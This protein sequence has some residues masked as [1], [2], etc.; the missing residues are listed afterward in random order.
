MEFS[1]EENLLG[2]TR[3]RLARFFRLKLSSDFKILCTYH[4]IHAL[5]GGMI[6][7]FLP[8]FLL[9]EFNN[10][11]YWVIVFYAAGHLVYGLLAPFGAMWMEKIGLKKS[12]II[13][14][15]F[16]IV[17]YLVLYFLQQN[18]L[19]FAILANLVL[20]I[21]RLCGIKK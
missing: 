13:G 7:L 12:M 20:M 5:A 10:S 8:I 14:R 2:T 11:V 3:N 17:F 21:F 16:T 4:V 19:L 18:P 1:T 15:F 6:G 9:R